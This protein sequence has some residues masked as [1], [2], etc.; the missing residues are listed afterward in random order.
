MNRLEEAYRIES[1]LAKRL[2][3]SPRAS[4]VRVARAV[5]A[6][7]YRLV[8][9]HPDLT[10]TP[11][12][13]DKRIAG[14]RFAYERWISS[15]RAVLEIGSG[16]CDLLARIGHEY[17]GI[18]FAGVDIAR[19]PLA[20]AGLALPPN[21]MFVQA[22]GT[23]LPFNDTSFDFVFCSQ[24]LEHFHP[25][26]VP[27]HLA[28]VARVLRPGGWFGFDTPNRITGPHDVSR[29]F[30]RE[31]TGLH[32]KEWTFGELSS[33]LAEYDFHNV[34]ARGLPGRAVRWLRLRTPGPLVPA[35][36]KIGLESRASRLQDARLRRFF[37]R[38]FGLDGIYLYAQKSS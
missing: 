33:L 18:A 5:Y 27:D 3:S 6:D 20:K 34:L 13:R 9:W 29:G 31:A 1:R 26:D 10:R 35:R 14:I 30:S 25:D 23:E 19:D 21:V 15:A 16:S 36:R 8:H 2:R 32:L 24:V 37:G 38:I 7:L 17:P 22:A 4:R 12:E 28:E 11:A